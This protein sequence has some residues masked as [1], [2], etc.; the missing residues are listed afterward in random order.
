MKWVWLSLSVLTIAWAYL[1]YLSFTVQGFW[2]YPSSA[3]FGCFA[4]TGYWGVL[5]AWGKDKEQE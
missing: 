3:L 5:F 1:T 2:L 4:I